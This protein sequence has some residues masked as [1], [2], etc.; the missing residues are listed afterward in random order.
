MIYSQLIEYYLVLNWSIR[1]RDLE[2][3]IYV[4]PKMTNLFFIFNQQNYARY[5]VKYYDNLIKIDESHPGLRIDLEKA[6]FGIK[7]TEKGF[8]AQPID[9]TLEQT[10]NADA[11]NKLTGIIHS[12]NSI[13]ARQR[14]C[15]S[16]SLRT[17]IISHV[18]DEVGLKSRQDI[19][20]IKIYRKKE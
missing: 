15:K 12:T 11:A 19:T 18:L 6:S 2:L 4:L 10:I 7:R 9:L 14:W 5:L 13:S 8:S 16:H 1:T 20:D 3:F 17:S